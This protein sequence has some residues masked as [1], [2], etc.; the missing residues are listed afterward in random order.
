MP[1]WLVLSGWLTVGLELVFFGLW[2]APSK[3]SPRIADGCRLAIGV[4]AV[5][6]GC[7]ALLIAAFGTRLVI[8]RIGFEGLL[9]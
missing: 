3:H 1:V 9:R 4:V 2:I 6:A 7:S 5:F 8:S